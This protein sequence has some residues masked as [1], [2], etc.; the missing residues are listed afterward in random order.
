[1]KNVYKRLRH[2]MRAIELM[3]AIL[4]LCGIAGVFV[5]LFV[6]TPDSPLFVPVM[7][8]LFGC[9]FGMIEAMSL[10]RWKM[11]GRRRTCILKNRG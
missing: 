8:W 1:M 9:G 5:R 3:G 11:I 4:A 6:I 10:L 7:A 2:T